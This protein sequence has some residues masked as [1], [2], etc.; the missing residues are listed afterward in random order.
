MK[1]ESYTQFE[2]VFRVLYLDEAKID[3][4]ETINTNK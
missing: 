4:K 2:L 1:S 3:T